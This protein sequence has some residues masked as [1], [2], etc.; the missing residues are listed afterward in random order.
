MP[1]APGEVA[2]I[3][4]PPPGMNCGMPP[5][6]GPAGCCAPGFGMIDAGA[7]CCPVGGRAVC[8]SWPAIGDGFCAPAAPKSDLPLEG[9]VAMDHPPG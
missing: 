5:G 2:G 8:A 4:A 3:R 7:G 6:R 1:G 9:I